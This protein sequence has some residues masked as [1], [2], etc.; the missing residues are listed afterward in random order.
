MT[1]GQKEAA[2]AARRRRDRDLAMVKLEK[3]QDARRH[4]SIT[5]HLQAGR[6]VRCEIR[7]TEKFPGG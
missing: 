6:I 1:A 4:G 7:T 3:E 5:Y 2:A